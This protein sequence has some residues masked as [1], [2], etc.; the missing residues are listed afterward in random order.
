MVAESARL[1]ADLPEL[2]EIAARNRIA[3]TVSEYSPA[4]TSDLIESD[5]PDAAITQTQIRGLGDS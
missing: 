5:S 1:L 4:P 2:D 3:E